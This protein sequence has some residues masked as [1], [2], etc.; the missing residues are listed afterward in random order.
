MR[1][2]QKR[3]TAR[4]LRRNSTDVERRMWR[5]LRDRRFAGVKF[6]RQVPIG[7][8]IADFASIQHRLA[9]EVDGGQHGCPADQR[10]DLFL[11]ARGW[12]VI[13]F[14]NNDVLKN[15]NGVLEHLLNVTQ[16]PSPQPS[17]ASAGEGAHRACRPAFVSHR[18]FPLSR[19]RERVPNERSE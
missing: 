10:R 18:A 2:G 19:L 9:V 7:P 11:A 6:R 8:Y 4:T 13:R 17:P 1:D 5:L 12:R 14:W 15:R 3:D 16:E